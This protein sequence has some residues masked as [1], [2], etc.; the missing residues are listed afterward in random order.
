MYHASITVVLESPGTVYTSVCLI[1]NYTCKSIS[2]IACIL[3]LPQKRSTLFWTCEVGQEWG[4]ADSPLLYQSVLLGCMLVSMHVCMHETHMLRCDSHSCSA[5]GRRALADNSRITSRPVPVQSDH[6]S[7]STLLRAS[8]LLLFAPRRSEASIRSTK[9]YPKLVM[10]SCV[11]LRSGATMPSV[12]LGVFLARS[13]KETYNA[14]LSSLKIGYRHVDTARMYGN[15]ADV[16][17]AVKASGLPRDQV[18]ITSKI[19]DVDWG[20]EAATSAINQSLTSLNMQY[21]DLMLMHHPGSRQGRKETWQALEDA[22]KK[23]CVSL[24]LLLQ[25]GDAWS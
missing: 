8:L 16:G 18:F 25:I 12:G 14:V 17:K 2:K 20:Y 11:K 23:V 22:H 4:A 15:E 5:H 1:D 3:P 13:G 9:L 21:I 19:F 7:R 6:L 24:H 10:S